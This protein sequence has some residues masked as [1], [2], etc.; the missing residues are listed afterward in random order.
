M[1]TADE[2]RKLVPDSPAGLVTLACEAIDNAVR[3]LASLGHKTLEINPYLIHYN[4]LYNCWDTSHANPLL[5]EL[6]DCGYTLIY[7]PDDEKEEITK[8]SISWA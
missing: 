3:Q 2:A 6:E 7:D 1:I 8:Y 5:K 4:L